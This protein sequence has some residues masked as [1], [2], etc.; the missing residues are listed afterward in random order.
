MF[1][2]CILGSDCTHE[3][4][5]DDS[6]SPSGRRGLSTIHVAF[7]MRL[8]LTFISGKALLSGGKDCG[9]ES[10]RRRRFRFCLFTVADDFLA[11]S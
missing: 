1:N 2:L 7:C 6:Q 5:T 8:P 11:T 10:H 9:F 3:S 4:H